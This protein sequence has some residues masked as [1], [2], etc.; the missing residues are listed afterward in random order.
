MRPMHLLAHIRQDCKNLE[1]TNALAYLT[2]AS[3]REKT[4]FFYCRNQNIEVTLNDQGQIQ[5]SI[6][7]NLFSAVMY[8]FFVISWSVCPWQAFPA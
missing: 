1:G 6:L 7:N 4:R 8:D 3:V 2:G 5:V